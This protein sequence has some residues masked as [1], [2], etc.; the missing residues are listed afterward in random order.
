MTLGDLLAIPLRRSPEATALVTHGDDGEE[1]WSYSALFAAVRLLAAHLQAWGL[2][3]G[4]RVALFLG[5]GAEL[6]IAYLAVLAAGA[7]VV[8]INLAYRRR[9]I[10]HILGDAEPRVLVTEAEQEGVLAEIPDAER[11]SVERVL[12]ASEIAALAGGEAAA[13]EAER[14]APPLVTSAD[15]AMILYTSGTTGASKGAMLALGNVVATVAALLAAWSFESRDRLLLT[16]PL[17]HVHGLI[18]GLT[19]T[20]AAGGTVDLRRRFDAEPVV[21]EL[22]SGRPTL[23][24]G[25]PTMYVRLVAELA[26]V[27]ESDGHPPDLSSVRL[28]CSGSAPLA[29]ETFHAFARLS[30]HDILERYGMTEAGILLSNLYAGPRRPGTVGVPLPGVAIQVVDTDGQPVPPGTDGELWVR[31]GNVFSGYFRAPE[32]TAA[33]FRTDASGER[34]FATG[35]LARIDLA[36]AAV[37]LL[38]RRHEMLISGGFNV[39]PR[40]IEE[41]LC[42]FP[43]IREAAVVGRPHLE[44]GEVPV[45]FLVVDRAIVED[46]LL[47]FCR[48]QMAAFKVPREL[49][50]V[51][52][53]PRNAL[54]KVQKNLL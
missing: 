20:L 11:R 45:A 42:T 28:F 18:V 27:A 17:F 12:I 26:R 4:D 50:Y 48:G 29:A 14:F 53:L 21:A 30:G 33:S 40:E 52:A 9:E 43:G 15:L 31:G 1:A 32:K 41:V 22:A 36:T 37:T 13:D 25:V 44:W 46:D 23:F 51:D 49:R 3:P 5:N 19:T 7:V 38:G 47:A 16:L 8:P 24:F 10:A 54:G 39:Y 35:D 2:R 6:V 34:W